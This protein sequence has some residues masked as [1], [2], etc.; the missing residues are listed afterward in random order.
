M[1]SQTIWVVYSVL[2]LGGGC[3]NAP[4]ALSSDYIY[5]IGG[6]TADAIAAWD[7]RPTAE[8]MDVLNEIVAR[9]DEATGCAFHSPEHLHRPHDLAYSLMTICAG[10]EPFREWNEEQA[11]AA[12]LSVRERYH[13]VLNE[14]RSIDSVDNQE[15]AEYISFIVY[16]IL[17][18]GSQID[19]AEG[20]LERYLQTNWENDLEVAS[21]NLQLVISRLDASVSL[22]EILKGL[23]NRCQIDREPILGHYQAEHER[24]SDLTAIS[25]RHEDV[26]W[27]INITLPMLRR[28]LEHELVVAAPVMVAAA[29]Y[30]VGLIKALEEKRLPTYEEAV[31]LHNSK[32]A[33]NPTLGLQ[34]L[35][36]W[37]VQLDEVQTIWYQVHMPGAKILAFSGMTWDPTMLECVDAEAHSLEIARGDPGSSWS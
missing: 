3:L 31:Y 33:T 30:E 34:N 11:K 29:S 7:L 22:V 21:R 32:V 8:T 23:E 36:G 20:R 17:G 35:A 26:L 14:M 4:S 1:K 13:H 5:G 15:L 12:L 28:A 25:T 9:L 16:R 27:A 19:V 24:L 10:S 18:L 37:W 6:E 2:V